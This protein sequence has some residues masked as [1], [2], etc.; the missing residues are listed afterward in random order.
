V[1]TAPI[2]WGSSSTPA[3]LASALMT[4]I[5]TAA[6]SYVTASLDSTGEVINLKSVATSSSSNYGMQLNITDTTAANNPAYAPAS[7]P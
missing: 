5:N 2:T 4:K 7:L 6:G 1:T 3:S